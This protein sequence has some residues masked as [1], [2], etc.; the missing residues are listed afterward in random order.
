MSI[1]ST[2]IVV[3]LVVFN[4]NVLLTQQPVNSVPYSNLFQQRLLSSNSFLPGLGTLGLNDVQKTKAETKEVHAQE[5]PWLQQQKE[6][7]QRVERSQK[8]SYNLGN[9]C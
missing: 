5:S 7:L 6:H 1:S 8:L 4:A 9:Y 2:V 3:T